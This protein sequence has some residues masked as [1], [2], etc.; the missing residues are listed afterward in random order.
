MTTTADVNQLQVTSHHNREEVA[1]IVVTF[2]PELNRL[3]VLLEATLAQVGHVYVVDNGDGEQLRPSLLGLDRITLITM[4]DNQGI[5]AAQ[6]AGASAALCGG[7]RY[8]LLLDQDSVPANDMVPRL[9]D[10]LEALSVEGMHVGAV[11]PAS[12]SRMAP[13]RFVRFGWFRYETVRFTQNETF[14]WCDML[15]ASGTLIPATAW[16]DIG[17]M[18]ETLFIDKV[19][20]EWCLRAASKGYRIAGV[21]RARLE[22]S[23]GERSIRLWLG[24][25]R[26]VPVHHPFRYYYIIRTGLLIARYPH[27]SW[28]WRTAELQRSISI[29]FFFG[30]AAPARWSNL[31]M[32]LRGTLAGLIGRSGPL[33]PPTTNC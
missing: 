31:G 32:M 27:A 16:S 18:D 29:V 2:R 3:Q 15:I 33:P 7:A 20:T 13:A 6:N 10:T 4:G 25:W 26:H 9:I 5:G 11:G 23:L 1:A 14:V 21:P 19:D 30:L 22:H 28:R 17:P 12:P 24:R 8:L